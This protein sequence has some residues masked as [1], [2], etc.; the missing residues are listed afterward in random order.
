MGNKKKNNN[1]PKKE[2]AKQTTSSKKWLI[3]IVAAVLVLS[4]ALTLFLVFRQSL[5]ERL[6]KKIEKDGNYQIEATVNDIPLFGSISVKYMSDGNISYTSAS[7]LTE[8]AYKEKSGDDVYV[9]TKTENGTWVKTKQAEGEDT[10]E[11]LK[12]KYEDL[13][14]LKNYQKIKGQ[15]NTYKLKDD[16]KLEGFE[17]VVAT[18]DKG[19]CVVTCTVTIYGMQVNATIVVSEIGNVKLTLPKV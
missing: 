3:I 1:Q 10:L 13:L 11:D 6:I 7:L 8:E 5:A 2:P 12:E 16:V 17:N 19:K 18:F 15:K 9:Y 14:D 4:I